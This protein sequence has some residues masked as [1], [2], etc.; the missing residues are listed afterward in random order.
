MA[1]S[2]AGLGGMSFVLQ[3][4]GGRY[5]AITDLPFVGSADEEACRQVRAPPGLPQGQHDVLIQQMLPP[6]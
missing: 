4:Q 2:C 5:S 1:W 6:V 3:R